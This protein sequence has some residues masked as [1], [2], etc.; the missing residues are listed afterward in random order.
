[1]GSHELDALATRM[2]R[3]FARFEYALKATGFNTGDGDAKA[4]WTTFAQSIPSAFDEPLKEG[5]REAIAY[6]FE[7]PPKKQIVENG[8]LYWRDVPAR[9]H[10]RSD[11]LLIYV[12][13]V[14]NN[15]FHGGKFN[16]HWFEPQRSEMLILHSLLILEECL[17]VSSPVREAYERY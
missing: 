8:K 12:R 2:F 5:L 3:T 6:M 16:G 14:R 13:R 7:Y 11:Q 15:L 4:N 17:K 10:L 9:T 1:M